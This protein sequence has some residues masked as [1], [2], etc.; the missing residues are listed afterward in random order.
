MLS[1]YL[2][3]VYLCVCRLALNT[4]LFHNKHILEIGAGNG[5]CGV[6]VASF[7]SHITM[8]D[9]NEV[10]LHNIE[11]IVDLNSGD[12]KMSYSND[13]SA[14]SRSC[15]GDD[16]S[17]IEVRCDDIPRYMYAVVD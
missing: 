17:R 4:S 10:V 7:A 2:L 5:L 15:L 13:A 11:S 12:Y 6:T 8:S 3:S 1:R 14:N 9:F 16:T